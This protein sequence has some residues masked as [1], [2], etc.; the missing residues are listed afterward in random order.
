M[1]DDSLLLGQLAD[2][3]T[4]RVRGG[5][6]PEVEEYASRHPGLAPRIRELF[7]TLMLLEGFAGAGAQRTS[8]PAPTIAPG[9]V[10]G[11]YRIDRE[12][13]RGGMGVVYEAVH[14]A[15]GK[16]VALKV[17]LLPSTQSSEQLER[18]LREARTAAS[19]HHTNIVPVFD[20]GQ[21]GGVPYYAMQYIEGE[22][23]DR[24]IRG[25]SA[26]GSKAESTPADPLGPTLTPEAGAEF[27][28]ALSDL[29][30]SSATPGIAGGGRGEV[31]GVGHPPV[32][33]ATTPRGRLSW[34]EYFRW[35]A[36]LG[37]QAAS[38]IAH[39]HQRGVIHRD[40]KPSNL[41]LDSQ[42]V[43]WI[44]DFGL[45]RRMDDPGLTKSGSLLGTPRYMSPE[46]A[47]AAQ[48][49]IDHRTDIYSLGASLYELLACRP[50]FEGATPMEVVIQILDR[51][52]VSPRRL[53]PAVPADLET[54]VLKAM[55]KRPE[56]RY[57]TAA[58]VA[59]DLTRWLHVEPIRA[60][61]IG[62]MGRTV[63][64]CRRNPAV[65]ALLATVAALLITIAVASSLTAVSMR[66]LAI[67]ERSAASDAERA[68]QDAQNAL[69]AEERALANEREARG[70]A[71]AAKE[72]A[73]E[74][75]LLA[76]TAREQ[77]DQ[78]RRRAETSHEL[79]QDHLAR[80]LYEQAHALNTSR[81]TGRRWLA[82]DRLREAELLRARVR[83]V[84]AAADLPSH[85]TDPQPRLPSRV[86]LRSEA[87]AALLGLDGRVRRGS[88]LGT[89]SIRVPAVSGNGRWLAVEWIDARNG[90]SGVRLIDLAGESE[91]RRLELPKTA[92][93][94]LALDE[95]G[96]RLATATMTG[97]TIWSVPSGEHLESLAWPADNDD[98][99]TVPPRFTLPGDTYVV[100]APDRTRIAAIRSIRKP[101]AAN[102]QI[103][104]GLDRQAVAWDLRPGGEA[105][106]LARGNLPAVALAFSPDGK[107]LAFPSSAS[108]VSL[109]NS[110]TGESSFEISPPAIL[111]GPLAFAAGNRLLAVGARFDGTDR[112]AVMLWNFDENREVQRIE[113][114]AFPFGSALAAS[115]DGGHL[116][117]GGIRGE[118]RVFGLTKGNEA[119][120]LEGGHITPITFVQWAPDGRG[121]I[122]VAMDGSVRQWELSLETPHRE[123]DMG[124]AGASGLAFSPDGRRVAVA[125]LSG[126]PSVSSGGASATGVQSIKLIDRAT[127]RV[128][129]EWPWPDLM[130]GLVFRGDGQRLAAFSSRLAV[131]WELESGREVARFECL[132]PATEESLQSCGFGGDGNLLVTRIVGK[133]LT[134]VDAPTGNVVWQPPAVAGIQMGFLSPDGKLILGLPK[135]DIKPKP[136]HL[137]QLPEGT[138][139]GELSGLGAT[140]AAAPI[141]STDRRWMAIGYLSMDIGALRQPVAPGQGKSADY[142]L[143][144]WDLSAAQVHLDVRGSNAPSAAAISND[145]RLL[146]IG[147][148]DGRVELWDIPL[149]KKILE[150]RG[151]TDQVTKLAFTPE[152]TALA[153]CDAKSSMLQLLEIATLRRELAACELDW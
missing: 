23:L 74:Q 145:S 146:A 85:D 79:A 115:P 2:E 37:I 89:I 44:T 75:R 72:Q 105:R 109:W 95:T 101:P 90:K 26:D 88:E 33:G 47:A 52:P 49:P 65:A 138:E 38:G 148:V 32:P 134:V 82:L 129:R 20:V 66:E 136:W 106:V 118:I 132:K 58:E 21:S 98:K 6:L 62:P 55:A 126:N 108:S 45:A 68:R 70:R 104:A 96:T 48:H 54:I 29:A 60:R 12:L 150:W 114:S 125:P 18:F 7:P 152:G 142:G 151:S 113:S 107:S 27:H 117:C 139:A 43:L 94:S 153:R 71:E 81:Q 40:I 133:E 24:V 5:E 140:N 127:S 35:T 61:K 31:Q 124:M 84:G 14:Q 99:G 16:R 137:W 36:D 69:L 39:A 19:L 120:R 34:G 73:H 123:I 57:Q 80:S 102:G 17:L 103:A 122:S 51:E 22:G 86:E 147:Y 128:D 59:D 149:C 121:L 42:G 53:N 41:I 135:L 25:L 130:Q 116:A 119:L 28:A 141:F 110:E 9:T 97:V 10:F 63:R 3:F 91:E 11:N 87:L 56:D 76:E 111:T 112:G 67:K 92:F 64:W 30:S 143:A 78:Q 83:P 1:P 144:L 131:A 46:Q 93:A 8:A 13:G 77:A 100:F 50:A 15:L 4:S